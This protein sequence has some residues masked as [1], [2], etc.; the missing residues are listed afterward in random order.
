LRHSLSPREKAAPNPGE[1]VGRGA[2]VA[3][4]SAAPCRALDGEH[5]TR[6]YPL[7]GGRLAS[8][9]QITVSEVRR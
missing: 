3:N 4:Q 8:T 6:A 2:G 5:R 7:F 1:D 9:R